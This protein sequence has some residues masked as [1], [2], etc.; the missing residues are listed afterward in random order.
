[1][2][3]FVGAPIAPELAAEALRVAEAI[4]SGKLGPKDADQVIDVV[5]KM[6]EASMHHFFVKPIQT[7]GGGM[8]MRGFAEF[9]V[10]SAS[11][12]IRFGLKKIL[13]KLKQEQWQQIGTLLDEALFDAGQLKK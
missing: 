6:T 7:F 2:R 1:M 13:P 8:T 12:A 4:K 11:K 3:N 10:S 9:G 5:S